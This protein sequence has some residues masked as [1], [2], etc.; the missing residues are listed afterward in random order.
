[1]WKTSA[2]ICQRLV[3][4][5]QIISCVSS[6]VADRDNHQ[7]YSCSLQCFK[8]HKAVCSNVD[9]EKS[10][11]P[12]LVTE[13]FPS[14][15]EARSLPFTDLLVRDPRLPKLF[16]QYPSLRAKL[17]LI[18]Q[19]AVSAEQ[20]EAYQTRTPGAHK[21][22]RSLEQRIAQAM[23]MLE[24]NLSSESADASGMTAFAALVA[25]LGFNEQRQTRIS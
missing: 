8:T 15:E 22:H 17:Q 14:T 21:T 16:E 1:M 9:P 12:P 7:H 2:P 11:Q 4:I 3:V 5:T 6:N 23:R 20:E 18:F 24:Y 10:A 19:T 25:D 13:I